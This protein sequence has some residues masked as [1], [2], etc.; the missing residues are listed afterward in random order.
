MSIYS[1]AWYFLIYALIGWCLEVLFCTVNTGQL[2]NRGFLNGPVCPI[3]GFGGVLVIGL[4]QPVAG[5]MLLLYVG[6]VLV[7]SA[8]ELAAGILLKKVFHTSWW[9]YSDVPFNLGGYIC[10]KFSLMWGVA[11]VVL[12]RVVHPLVEAGVSLLPVVVGRVLLAVFYGLL[13]ADVAVTVVAVSKMNMDLEEA[14]KIAAYLRQGSDRMAGALGATALQVAGKLEELELP[15]KREKAA[16]DMAAQKERLLDETNKL[17]TSWSEAKEKQRDE[18][19]LRQ[20]RIRT[21]LLKAFPQMQ[22]TRNKDAFNLM[23]QRLMKGRGDKDS[24]E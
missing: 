23:K 21:R 22:N 6:S 4:L 17:K 16:Q 18:L 12:I 24:E 1:A 8:L 7:T 5:N 19:L 3:Y 11:C 9:D 20:Q 2:V 15:E 13:L 10:L 14:G